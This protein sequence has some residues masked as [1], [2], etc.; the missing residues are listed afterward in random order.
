M[1]LPRQTGSRRPGTAP[2]PRWAAAMTRRLRAVAAAG[3][4]ASAA[5]RRPRGARRPASPSSCSPPR[6]LPAGASG[7]EGGGPRRGAAQARAVGRSGGGGPCV[8]AAGAGAE[9]CEQGRLRRGP[10]PHGGPQAG[11]C[12]PPGR[13]SRELSA[14]Q[15]AA[16]VSRGAGRWGKEGARLEGGFCG[17]LLRARCRAVGLPG[18]LALPSAAALAE[19]WACPGGGP[20]PAGG[21]GLP[22]GRKPGRVGVSGRSN[23][24]LCRALG[25]AFFLLPWY[26][27]LKTLPEERPPT[28]FAL[29]KR[30]STS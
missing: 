17:F 4:G 13:L 25:P 1:F 19:G 21:L 24:R 14:V 23:D 6:P 12:P 8:S 3:R 29:G 27:V 18:R 9:R 10:R 20:R 5:G 22:C 11:A 15:D 7:W 2:P 28:A 26:R 30:R 16:A